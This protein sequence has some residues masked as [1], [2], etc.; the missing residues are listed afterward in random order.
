VPYK[1]NLV[2]IIRELSSC[3]KNSYVVVQCL[4]GVVSDRLVLDG[5]LDVIQVILIFLDQALEATN[6]C[7]NVFVTFRNLFH[8]VIVVDSK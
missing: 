7:L 1:V 4:T 5:L 6:S 3:L 2:G 8:R